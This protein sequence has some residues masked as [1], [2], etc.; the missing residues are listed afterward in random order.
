MKFQDYYFKLE[1]KI[2]N[3]LDE[4]PERVTYCVLPVLRW[5]TANG[6]YNSVTVTSSLKITKRISKSFLARRI[7]NAIHDK[8]HEYHLRDL[9]IDLFLM[10]RPW[11]NFDEFTLTDPEITNIL[12]EQMWKEINL[13]SKF[14]SQDNKIFLDKAYNLLNYEFKDIIMNNYGDPLFN[15]NNNLIGYKLNNGDCATLTTYY[16]EN[17]L[18]CNN[19]EIKEFDLNNLTFIGD[20]LFTWVDIKV[21]NG[22]IRN[23]NN[24]NI[25][26]IKIIFYLTLKQLKTVL[27]FL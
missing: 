21:E 20:T 17:N 7:S 10:G 4:I 22:F 16:N 23:Y 8:I 19:I 15:K 25:I 9:D 1:Q 12:G 6:E 27:L 26:M 13:I 18:L 14:S 3:F 24:K 11:L 5:E 2:I